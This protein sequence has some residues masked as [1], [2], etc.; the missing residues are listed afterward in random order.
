MFRL[1]V[2]LAKQA[3]QL[4]DTPLVRFLC[5]ADVYHALGVWERQR[6]REREREKER[7]REILF[8]IFYFIF[9]VYTFKEQHVFQL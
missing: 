8:H 5:K 1:Y 4:C 3:W 2:L 9:N 6:E 7:E